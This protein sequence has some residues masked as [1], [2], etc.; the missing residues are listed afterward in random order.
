MSGNCSID[1]NNNLDKEY[2][3]NIML[4]DIKTYVASNKEI[5]FLIMSNFW[6]EET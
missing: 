2:T 6:R 4:K 3:L 1:D 5:Y